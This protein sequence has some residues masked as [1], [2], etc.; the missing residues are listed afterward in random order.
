MSDYTG[1]Q[2]KGYRIVHHATMYVVVVVENK[3][4]IDID[5]DN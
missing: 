4:H 2:G 3:A 5:I 1:A